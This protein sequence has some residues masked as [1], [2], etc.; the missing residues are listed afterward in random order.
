[1]IW[2]YSLIFHWLN[3]IHVVDKHFMLL[4]F[5]LWPWLQLNQWVWPCFENVFSFCCMEFIQT[6]LINKQTKHTKS[7]TIRCGKVYCLVFD[8]WCMRTAAHVHSTHRS[9]SLDSS[10]VQ[11]TGIYPHNDRIS[12]RWSIFKSMISRH[13]SL[14]LASTPPHRFVSFRFDCNRIYIRYNI[15]WNIFMCVCD[16]VERE[17]VEFYYFT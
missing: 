11:S 1:M 6:H 12:V 4:F 3:A 2:Y 10:F 15:G 5:S 16:C 17:L 7:S 13:I 9:S 14:S 8:V